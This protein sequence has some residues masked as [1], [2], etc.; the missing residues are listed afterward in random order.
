MMEP[1]LAA[2]WLGKNH[3]AARLIP[4]PNGG[5]ARTSFLVASG[6]FFSLDLFG[7]FVQLAGHVGQDFAISLRFRRSWLK[8]GT[9]AHA[10][11]SGPTLRPWSA[12]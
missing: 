5:A 11:G 12:G 1:R 8:G 4:L 2:P 3:G 6:R 10:Y 7:L 9:A